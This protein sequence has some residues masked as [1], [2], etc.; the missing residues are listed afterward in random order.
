MRDYHQVE[1]RLE[2]VTELIDF[3]TETLASNPGSR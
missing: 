2:Q 1:L 3:L